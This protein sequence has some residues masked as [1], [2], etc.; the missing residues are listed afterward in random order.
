MAPAIM[1]G[2]PQLTVASKKKPVSSSTSVQWVTAGPAI[3]ESKED[4][5]GKSTTL[6]SFSNLGLLLLLL[7][8]SVLLVVWE[9]ISV[10]IVV[11]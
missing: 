3:V 2:L 9:W 8:V 5:R 10:W 1:T 6:Y 7:Q 11:D 4:R